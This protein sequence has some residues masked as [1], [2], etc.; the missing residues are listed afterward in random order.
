MGRPAR[1]GPADPAAPL[2]DLLP[3]PFYFT[4]PLR[5]SEVVGR[6]G[7]G[8]ATLCAFSYL[9]S[10]GAPVPAFRSFEDWVTERFGKRLYDAFFRS[11]TEKVWGIPGSEIRSEWAAQRIKNFSFSKALLSML[12]LRREHVTSLIEEFRYPRLGPGQMWR[13]LRRPCSGGRRADPPRTVPP[14][15]HSGAAST[16]IVGRSADG[17]T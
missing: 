9:W 11:Y 12:R 13:A 7:I 16:S 15:R 8:E 14:V 2:A 6:L 3:Q 5:P 10:A 17:E 1:R 4:Y